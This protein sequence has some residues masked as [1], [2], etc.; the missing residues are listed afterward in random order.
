MSEGQTEDLYE[1]I[2]LKISVLSISCT[3][4][5]PPAWRPKGGRSGPACF[6]PLPGLALL[7]THSF[8]PHST[9]PQLPLLLKDGSTR[10]SWGA[11]G[12]DPLGHQA[13]PPWYNRRQQHRCKQSAPSYPSMVPRLSL[14]AA[15]VLSCCAAASGKPGTCGL[16]LALALVSQSPRV[17]AQALPMAGTL[18]QPWRSLGLGS[19][20]WRWSSATGC[21][22]QKIRLKPHACWEAV[23]LR[24]CP[25]LLLGK[26][27]PL[28][29]RKSHVQLD[30]ACPLMP[31]IHSS[32]L[33]V[34]CRCSV[35]CALCCCLLALDPLSRAHALQPR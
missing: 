6:P 15:L 22:R 4:R 25:P 7:N 9:P 20:A 32:A 26:L 24:K 2:C 28:A 5:G 31:P 19:E 34:L 10:S 29:S 16:P 13:K 1:K 21:L 11:A 14:V 35:R 18:A 33:P 3:N 17:W 27:V 30:S 12:Q 8:Q 23:C